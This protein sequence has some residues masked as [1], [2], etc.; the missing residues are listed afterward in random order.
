MFSFDKCLAEVEANIMNQLLEKWY[1]LAA[2]C[3]GGLLYFW[4]LGNIHPPKTTVQLLGAV[5]SV[6]GIAVG[7]LGAAQ[8]ILLSIDES[9][10]I[11]HLQKVGRYDSVMDHLDTAMLSSFFLA[12]FSGIGLLKDFE[13]THWPAWVVSLWVATL[14]TTTCSCY[15]VI[16][17]FKKILRSPK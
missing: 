5:V 10:I 15:R 17:L 4:L 7:F 13:T 11:R 1:H 8:S 3:I 16:R 14:I 12:V 9:K 2:G 6:A